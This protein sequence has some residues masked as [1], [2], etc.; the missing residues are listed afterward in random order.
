MH[1]MHSFFIYFFMKKF[2]TR[3]KNNYLKLVIIFL[4]LI[5]FIIISFY[6]LNKSYD[7]L[8]GILT[9]NFKD[10]N[11]EIFSLTKNLD[12]LINSYSFKDIENVY[13]E[14]NKKIYL[15]STHDLEIY[16][17][18]IEIENVLDL[19]KE[20][21][22]KLG[23]EVI[24]EEKKTSELLHTG[25]SPYNISRLFLEEIMQKDKDIIYYID[26]HCNSSQNTKIHFNNKNYAQIMFVLGLDNKNY[27]N[28][29]KVMQEMNDYLNK[30]YPGIS[31]GIYEKHGSG[32]DGVYNQ[33]LN[34][35]VILLEVGGIDNNLEEINNST[36]IL[37]LM[38]YHMLGD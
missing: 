31:K 34:S 13:Q 10:D 25:L 30:N 33:D 38:I 23:I 18:K 32:V 4:L 5:L 29:K 21:L 19:F 3:R 20:N 17:D 6:K 28:N 27:V 22:S 26:I 2:K 24:K 1:K 12:Y 7:K 37:S 15:Y 14:K 36:E 9:R 35:N 11:I 8:V 16:K